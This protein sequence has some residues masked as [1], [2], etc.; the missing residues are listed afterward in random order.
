MAVDVHNRTKKNLCGY[1]AG[2]TLKALLLNGYV[3]DP[4]HNFVSDVSATEIAGNGYARQTLGSLV[5]SQ[6]DSTNRGAL[7][8]ADIAFG[9]VGPGG[10]QPVT[11]LVVYD[12]AGGADSAREVVAVYDCA[13]T[14]DG[15][16]FTAIINAAGLLIVS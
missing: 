4:D 1:L 2:R 8:C 7:D 10:G 5:A 3:D 12:D 11:T 9:A 15:D 14:L 13:V 6:D 16:T